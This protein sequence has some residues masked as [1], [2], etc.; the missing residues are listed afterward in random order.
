LEAFPYS[1]R[2]RERRDLTR[3]RRPEVGTHFTK[4]RLR[5]AYLEAPQAETCADKIWG[6]ERASRPGTRQLTERRRTTTE[7]VCNILGTFVKP[8]TNPKET[9]KLE[10]GTLGVIR[11]GLTRNSTR[12]P[13]GASYKISRL[14]GATEGAVVPFRRQKKGPRHGGQKEWV[15]RAANG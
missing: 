9:P 4:Q 8:P 11:G 15:E 2:E 1:S 7:I 5:K 10:G 3:V 14:G 13:G 6:K 12:I